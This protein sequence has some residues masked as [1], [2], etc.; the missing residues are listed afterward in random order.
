MRK[1]ETKNTADK[2]GPSISKRIQTLASE[3]KDRKTIVQ[4]MTG[5]LGRPIRYQH[6][7]NVL[8]MAELKVL[9][10][11]VK[12]KEKEEVTE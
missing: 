6:V 11:R 8:K 3:G 2:K 5:E 1:N 4:I 7:Y 10:A 12:S 9:E